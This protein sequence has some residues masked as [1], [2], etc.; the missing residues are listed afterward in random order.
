[1]SEATTDLRSPDRVVAYKTVGD[2]T[3]SLDLF[4]PDE[5]WNRP[6]PVI[7][8]FHGGG[9]NGGTP[10]QFYPQS[11]ALRNQ[12]VLCISVE[13]RLG[14]KHGTTP[15]EAI[16]DAF[17][18]MRFVK[19][20]VEEWGGDPERIAAGGGSAG[21]HLAAALATLIAEDLAGDAEQ[22]AQARPD[23]LLLFNPVF[24]NGP[25]EKGGCGND[26][27]G[28]RWQE[29]SPVH[30]FHSNVPPML[31][32]LGDNDSLIPVQNLTRAS[33]SLQALDVPHEFLVYPGGDHGFFNIHKHEGVFYRKTLSDLEVFLRTYGWLS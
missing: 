25:E 5:T 28:D 27:L 7:V 1:M 6:L 22:R 23:L 11:A 13:Y 33:E 30:N 26:R 21:G 4:L 9:W 32:M 17:D 10:G 16:Q 14:K 15:F 20:H 19:Q 3:L 31:V 8:W 24:D 12:G 2:I 18:A 29:A